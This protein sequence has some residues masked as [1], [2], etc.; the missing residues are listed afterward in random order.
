MIKNPFLKKGK[1]NHN[2]TVYLLKI[3]TCTCIINPL[4]TMQAWLTNLYCVYHCKG[5]NF[6]YLIM[7]NIHTV[8]FE[9]LNVRFLG[10]RFFDR[11]YFIV[12]TYMIYTQAFISEA[13]FIIYDVSDYFVTLKLYTIF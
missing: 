12:I 3:I 7:I 9:F 8:N 5:S 11:D 2:A 13:G 10:C 6:P 4:Y 1:F